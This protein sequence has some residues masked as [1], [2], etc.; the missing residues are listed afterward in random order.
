MAERNH[1]YYFYF[2]AYDVFADFPHVPPSART[3]TPWFMKRDEIPAY[4]RQD[5]EKPSSEVSL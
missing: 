5:K 4:E 3:G 1:S 2:F